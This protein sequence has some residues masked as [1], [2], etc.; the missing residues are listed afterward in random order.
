MGALW[1]DRDF[2]C[3]WGGETVS[4][5]GAQVTQLALPLAAVYQ[6][7]AGPAELGLL[8]AASY[9]P[10]LG[11]S[12]LIGVWVDRRARKPLMVWSNVARAVLVTSIPLCAVL[13]VLHIGYLYAVAFAIGTFTAIFDVSYQSYL[14]SLIARE[15]LVEGNSKLQASSSVAQVG[16]PA[17]AGVLVGWLT[18]PIAL[19]V[20]GASYVVS[21]LGLTA[22][23][24]PEPEPE[25][26]EQRTSVVRSIGE[27]L[28]LVFGNAYVRAC[29]LQA[30]T[31]NFCWMALQTVFVVYAAR[32]L[33]LSS[34]TI[35]LL[36][37]LG[38]LGS[39]LGAITA[40][41]VKRRLGLGRA[42]VAEVLLCCLAP[43]LLPLAP[44]GA[45][46]IAMM[47]LGLFLGQLGATTATIHVVS[48]RQAITPA[49]LLG[50]VNSGCRFL[51]WGPLPLGAF[52]GGVLGE[53]IG[54]RPAL[55]AAACSFVLALLWVVFSPVPRLT[56]FPDHPD[57]VP[58]KAPAA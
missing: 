44:G 30:G 55:F 7:D 17:L 19:L 1:G 45:A 53:S 2:L 54:L 32:Q 51:A 35:G 42:I 26:P 58:S 5:F 16:G 10:F 31:Y 50:R 47:A 6:L 27:G 38:A 24:R 23:R 12:L 22:I 25:R 40:G 37:A 14:P 49:R 9:A 57:S 46:G 34:S 3:L 13:D 48:L 11:L 28:R 43:L 56:E 36:F 52:V 41:A 39:L 33:G 20:N 15:H 21:V 29:A 8:N 18:A 4:Q